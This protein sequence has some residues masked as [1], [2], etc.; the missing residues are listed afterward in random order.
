MI[1]ATG[2]PGTHRS[3]ASMQILATLAAEHGLAARDV[4]V[5]TG[6]TSD[7]LADPA[8]VV[9]ADQELALIRNL[10]RHLGEVPALGLQAGLRYHFTA[11]GA[12]GLA[13]ASSPTLGSAMGVALRYIDLTF[14]LTRVELEREGGECRIVLRADDTPPEVVRFALERSVGVLFSLARDLFGD[15][16]LCK[17]LAF[18][19]PSPSREARELQQAL[20]GISPRYDATRTEVVLD[21]ADLDRPLLQASPVALHLAETECRRLMLERRARTGFAERV[22]DRVARHGGRPPDM[23]AVAAELHVTPRTLRRRLK[24]EGTTYSALCNEVRETYSEELLAVPDLSV[25]EIADRL[26]YADATSFI[27]A[28]KRWKGETPHR[29]RQGLSRRS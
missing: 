24:D 28:F 19:V 26:G 7:D 21:A 29:F 10:V 8:T 3:V 27:A 20:L 16:M 17:H 15:V 22:R 25:A 4:L 9:A 13:L 6:L 12:V 5:G 1:E 23:E 2:Q 14:A 18:A 11:L